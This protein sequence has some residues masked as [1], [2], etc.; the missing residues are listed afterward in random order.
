[1]STYKITCPACHWSFDNVDSETYQRMLIGSRCPKCKN[2]LAVK[3]I[4]VTDTQVSDK[5]S[6]KNFFLVQNIIVN[7]VVHFSIRIH[8]IPLPLLR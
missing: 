1:M 6:E 3:D 2:A 7:N 4:S 8:R 5:V